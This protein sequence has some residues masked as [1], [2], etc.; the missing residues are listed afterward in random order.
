MPRLVALLAA[1]LLLILPA[2][3]ET[4]H[5]AGLGALRGASGNRE[6]SEAVMTARDVLFAYAHLTDT[7][8][9]LEAL[10]RVEV[11]PPDAASPVPGAQAARYRAALRDEEAQL[12][13]EYERFNINQPL[14]L[15]VQTGIDRYDAAAGGLPLDFNPSFWVRDPTWRTDGFILRF[16]NAEAVRTVPVA[17]E[18]E[19]DERMATAGFDPRFD[20]GWDGVLELR[21]VFG[22]V[23]PRPSGLRGAP[24]A[25]RLLSARL[26]SRDG[27][28][29][30]D[31]GT[32]GQ[33]IPRRGLPVLATA[34]L[35]GLRLGMPLAEARAALP[36]LRATSAGYGM[37]EGMAAGVRRDP[38]AP[39]CDIGIVAD[40]RA[41]GQAAPPRY[42]FRHC[43]ALRASVPEPVEQPEKPT[44]RSA[45]PIGAGPASRTDEPEAVEQISEVTVLR[46]LPGL[47]PE[48]VRRQLERRFGASVTSGK[49]KITWI[50][51][52]PDAPGPDGQAPMVQLTAEFVALAEGGPDH[53]PGVL[54]GLQMQPYRPGP[55]DNS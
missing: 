45:G 53:E 15:R 10:A 7:R 28:V 4:P 19:A 22:G 43:I 6:A 14:L 40:L 27:E 3:A 34:K 46:F 52:D 12:R 18:G 51:Q 9:D 11:P 13:G 31:F 42:S 1:S 29:V 20:D 49:G 41:F 48:A 2:S 5:R 44:S 21:F 54:L 36:A 33:G 16:S 32:I 38:R 23:L 17:D 55:A 39:R 30:H 37:F 35:G 26:V 24:V 25:A 47:L 50:G 8:P